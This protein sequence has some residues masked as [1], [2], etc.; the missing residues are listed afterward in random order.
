MI[1][2]FLL[3]QLREDEDGEM[4][5]RMIGADELETMSVSIMESDADGVLLVQIDTP[6]LEE[7]RKGPRLRIALN[8]AD[9]YENPPLSEPPED[10]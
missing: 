10:A 8:D 6:R 4:K 5:L 2:D 9:V 7:N 1:H 3:S